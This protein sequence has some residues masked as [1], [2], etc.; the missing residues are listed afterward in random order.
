MTGDAGHGRKVYETLCTPCHRLREQI[1]VGPDLAMVSTKEDSRGCWWRSSTR[2][3]VDT[4][5]R[6]WSVTLKSGDVIDGLI[7]TETANNLVLRLAGGV[8][9]AILRED[10]AALEPMK[11]S[12][13]PGG[14]ETAIPPQDMADLFQ[15]LRSK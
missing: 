13:M 7:A 12:L 2:Q 1:E 8:E 14:F 11:V 5:Y 9:H 3:A 6:G 10:I 4:R 15:W